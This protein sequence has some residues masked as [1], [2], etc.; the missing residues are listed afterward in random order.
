LIVKS[1]ASEKDVNKLWE[2]FNDVAEGFG[3]NVDEMNE[4]CRVLQPTLEIHTKVEMD[5][6]STA[7][8][9]TMDT[10]QVSSSR[11]VIL[12]KTF[13]LKCI[14]ILEWSCGCFGIFRN[15]CIDV[16]HDNPSKIN[17]YVFC[18]MNLYRECTVY[19][20]KK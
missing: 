3:L 18:M 11:E 14:H 19:I 16:C 8:F 7:L 15:D 12:L 6:L 10:D 5:Q 2:T 13:L 9:T 20:Y 4:I 17:L 1:I